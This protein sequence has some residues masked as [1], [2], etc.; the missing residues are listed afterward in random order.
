MSA[1]SVAP[2][3]TV[4]HVSLPKLS[5]SENALIF[6]RTLIDVFLVSGSLFLLWGFGGM[7]FREGTLVN[8]NFTWAWICFFC[9]LTILGSVLR[10]PS[11]FSRNVIR[12]SCSVFL[13][14]NIFLFYLVATTTLLADYVF[15]LFFIGVC[16]WAIIA[17][18]LLF[19][20]IFNF[21]HQSRS[22]YVGDYCYW[23]TEH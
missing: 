7:V 3:P 8:P 5:N 16:T 6:L 10:S 23:S 13:L 11:P 14:A 9:S 4:N 19:G 20:S 12:V 22:L 15:Q 2:S 17:I 21:D 18:G 1:T